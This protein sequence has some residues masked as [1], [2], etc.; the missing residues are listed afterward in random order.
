M[1]FTDKLH[2]LGHDSCFEIKIFFFWK[3]TTSISETD[4]TFPHSYSLLDQLC[5]QKV[6]SL[7]PL[8]ESVTLCLWKGR[9]YK[10]QTATSFQSVPPP[11][12]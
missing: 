10:H 6:T 3:T 4:F 9:G 8:Y 5:A 1:C 2:E 12:A 11:V 7:L